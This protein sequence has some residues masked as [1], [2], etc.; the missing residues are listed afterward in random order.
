MI[1]AVVLAAGRD[2]KSGEPNLFSLLQGKPALQWV[3]ETALESDLHE[4]ICI[5]RDLVSVRQRIP[6]NERRLLWLA[7]PAADR[8][9]STSVIA[10][11]WAVDPNSHGALFLAGDQP[12]IRRELVHALIQ[13]FENSSALIVAPV[14][15]GQTRNPAL[16]R[17][18]VFP[19][20]LKLKG[21]QDGRALIEKW[22][23]ATELIEWDQEAPFMNIAAFPDY[24]RATKLA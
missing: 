20:L 23:S 18:D 21:D 5:A 12:L 19:E 24:E 11:L 15:A 4:V 17:R 6:I 1:S 8:G 16:F 14:F 7:N 9:Q 2:A 10:G 3:L 13:R 22:R